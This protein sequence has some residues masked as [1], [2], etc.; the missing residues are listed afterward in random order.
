MPN[1]QKNTK[2]EKWNGMAQGILQTIFG[3]MSQLWKYLKSKVLAKTL[4]IHHLPF[5]HHQ[6]VNLMEKTVMT[7]MWNNLPLH[8]TNSMCHYFAF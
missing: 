3:G 2:T 4:T 1:M 6:M 8:S 7:V 5:L